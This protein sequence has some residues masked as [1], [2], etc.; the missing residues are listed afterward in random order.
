MENIAKME[1]A[2]D[3]FKQN[4]IK[5]EKTFLGLKTKVTYI[6]TNSPVVGLYLEFDAVNGQ[7]VM[8]LLSAT[9]SEFEKILKKE[10]KPTTADNGNTRL[11]ICFSK[12]H[13]FAALQLFRYSNFE[14]HA[15]GDIRFIEGD[16]AE[17]EIGT[18][19]N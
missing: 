5:V 3:L 1:M 6:P 12:D 4:C 13:K 11:Y 9:P 15:V 18:F 10:G 17:M 8:D 16:M 19:V 14:Y 7:K 2:K